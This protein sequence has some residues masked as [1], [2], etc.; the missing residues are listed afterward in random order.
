MFSQIYY[1]LAD[2]PQIGA[3][4]V[5]KKSA[6]MMKG[7][8][9]KLFCLDLSFIGWYL[10][11]IVTLGIAFIWVGPYIKTANTIFYENLKSLTDKNTI[12]VDPL[13]V[14]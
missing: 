11:G 9:G 4:E 12:E 3:V 14:K 2:N 6:E 1:L 10:L 8:K 7:Y 13:E 5:L